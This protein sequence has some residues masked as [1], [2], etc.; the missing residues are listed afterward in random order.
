MDER[1]KRIERL[2][3]TRLEA[4]MTNEPI[5]HTCPESHFACFEKHHLA[6][7]RYSDLTVLECKNCHAKLTA[8]QK[9]HPPPDGGD[10][11]LEEVIGRFLLGLADFFELLI[12]N[13]NGRCWRK[14]DI[15]QIGL[16]DRFGS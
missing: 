16:N 9:G 4:L 13:A 6:G 2:K 11:S 7:K 10:P 12:D 1:K 15:G 3:Q 5:C 8:L 14:A